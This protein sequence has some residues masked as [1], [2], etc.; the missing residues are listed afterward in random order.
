MGV[1]AF[2]F[3]FAPSPTPRPLPSLSLSPSLLPSHSETYPYYRLP[4][5]PPANPKH[6]A[7]GLGAVS[8]FFFFFFCARVRAYFER[9]FFYLGLRGAG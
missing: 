4:F 5:C 7:D 6:K 3:V 8:V 1:G 9:I 2:V